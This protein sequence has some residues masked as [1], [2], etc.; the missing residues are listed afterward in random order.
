MS[1]CAE[2]QRKSANVTTEFTREGTMAMAS[3]TV[4]TAG[5]GQAALTEE[6]GVRTWRWSPEVEEEEAMAMA[7]ADGGECMN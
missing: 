6:A 3:S 4:S 2:R 5:S 1:V 7:M